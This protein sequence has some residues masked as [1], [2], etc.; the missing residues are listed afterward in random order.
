MQRLPHHLLDVGQPV[1]DISSGEDGFSPLDV[2]LLSTDHTEYLI[3]VLHFRE[4]DPD[5]VIETFTQVRLYGLSV[6]GL[7]EDFEELIIGQEIESWELS[8]LGL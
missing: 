1:L 7:R 5:D 4:F 6:S 3:R 8:S 2:L